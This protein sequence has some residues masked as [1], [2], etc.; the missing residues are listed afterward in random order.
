MGWG[1]V[2]A[3]DLRGVECWGGS[4]WTMGEKEVNFVG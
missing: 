2:G 4:D 3:G 1:R